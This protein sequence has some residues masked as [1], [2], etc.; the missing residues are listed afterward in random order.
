MKRVLVLGSTGSIGTNAIKITDNM[1]EDF[2]ICGLQAH[3]ASS[4]N[5]LKEL[6]EKYKCPTLLTSEDNSEA[7]FQRLIDQ[8]K[9]DIVVNGIAGASGLLPSKIVLE[10]K[11]DLALANKETIVMAGP[12]I[13]ALS[14]K[15]GA[16]LLPVDSEHSAICNLV[17]LC[18]KENIAKIVITASGGRLREY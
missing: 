13:K 1:P 12:L 8:S 18:G 14:R 5:A 9:P 3:S 11:I 6:G 17:N 16:R 7:A 2:T 4:K 15:T 10:N